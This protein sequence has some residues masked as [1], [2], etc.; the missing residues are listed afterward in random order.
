MHNNLQKKQTDKKHAENKDK[1]SQ[2]KLYSLFCRKTFLLQT[3]PLCPLL[4]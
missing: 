1:N 3:A 2:Y 4:K